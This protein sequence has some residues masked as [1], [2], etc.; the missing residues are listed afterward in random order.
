MHCF[1]K[2]VVVHIVLRFACISTLKVL[3]NKVSIK[4]SSSGNRHDEVP[5]SSKL[6]EKYVQLS[7]YLYSLLKFSLC[8]L[9][10]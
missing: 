4:C 1:T 6:N 10:H 7:I 9:S 5:R 2:H 3:T 8:S